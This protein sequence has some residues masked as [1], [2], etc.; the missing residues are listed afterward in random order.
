MFLLGS[1]KR[2][3]G[4]YTEGGELM[5]E[6]VDI[7]RR[8]VEACDC[9]QGFQMTHSLGGGTGAGF[10]TLLLLKIRDNYPDRINATYS[11][12][13]SPKVSD[14][15][16]EPY[17]A[18][19]S[20]H[21]LLENS[22]ETFVIDNEA[23]FK[24]STRILKQKEPKY[25][26]LNWVIAMAMSGVTASLRFSGKLN[27]DLRKLGVNLVPFPRLH[28]FVL[29]HTPLFA[30]NE[31]NKIDL[32]V[33]LIIDQMWTSKYFLSNIKA[34][35]GK[36]LSAACLFRGANIATQ[37]VDDGLA[38]TQQKIQ[39]GGQFVEW[40]PNNIK[41]SVIGVAPKQKPISGTF[42]ANTTAIKGVFQRIS[43]QFYRLY[44]RKAFLHWYK[45]EGMDELEFQEADNNVK[46][47]ITEYQDKQ[48]V[49]IEADD[50]DDDDGDG[51]EEEED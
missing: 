11:V 51:D 48:D 49:I 25:A 40:I 38:R 8:E 2:A 12:Y 28:F 29:S 39:S 47:L 31:A 34:Q 24:I 13:P 30:P 27:G 36:Y 14:V 44:K 20:I 7:I 5:E 21:Q 4:H 23:L 1:L 42:L 19:L 41:S 3:K 15:V 37:E 6:A 35:D 18:T 43:A 9:P 17:N 10:G 33:P 50:D 32:N 22:D 45:G 16:V 26:D 46:D